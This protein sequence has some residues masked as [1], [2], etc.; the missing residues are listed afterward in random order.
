MVIV[1]VVRLWF[2]STSKWHLVLA[3]LALI[4]HKK[5]ARPARFI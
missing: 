4:S 2:E 3:S 5:Q 1:A